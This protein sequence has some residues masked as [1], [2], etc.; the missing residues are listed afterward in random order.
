M[1]VNHIYVPK[2]CLRNIIIIFKKNFSLKYFQD[3]I[4]AIVKKI[5]LK[6]VTIFYKTMIINSHFLGALDMSLPRGR[7]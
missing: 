3:I 1:F 4:K 7:S 2:K 5:K 6:I